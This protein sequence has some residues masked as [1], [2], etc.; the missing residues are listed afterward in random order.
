MKYQDFR[1]RPWPKKMPP[2]S[3]IA[4]DGSGTGVASKDN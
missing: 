3:N 2:P 1:Q 4:A